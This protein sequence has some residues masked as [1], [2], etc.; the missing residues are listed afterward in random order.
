MLSFFVDLFDQV[1]FDIL[2]LC[3]SVCSLHITSLPATLPNNES[4]FY[5]IGRSWSPITRFSE[6]CLTS[7]SSKFHFYMHI[8]EPKKGLVREH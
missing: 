5:F 2:L 6:Q 4:F 1:Y 3:F 7:C 8:I